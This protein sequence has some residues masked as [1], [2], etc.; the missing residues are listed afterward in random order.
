[1]I[2]VCEEKRD[3]ELKAFLIL[4]STTGMRKGM[5][6]RPEWGEVDLDSRNPCIYVRL[7]ENNGAEADTAPRHRRRGAS[8]TAELRAP[9]IC[10]SGEA[11]PPFSG[12]ST[13]T[14]AGS[15]TTLSV[16]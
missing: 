14:S 13:L 9:R 2:R 7:T 8:C 16:C 15:R 6:S 12:I 10:F 5:D 1:M 4:A 3:L 11:E